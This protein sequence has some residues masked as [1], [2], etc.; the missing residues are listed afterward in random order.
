MAR[1]TKPKSVRIEFAAQRSIK[2][3]DLKLDPENI[4]LAHLSITSQSEIQSH[5][6]N[7]FKLKRLYDDIKNRGL[8]EPLILYPNN[9]IVAEGNCRLS[10]LLK[11]LEQ[12]TDDEI[13]KIKAISCKRISPNTSERDIDAYLA[14]IHVGQKIEWPE[15]NQAKLMHRL[16]HDRGLSLEEISRIVRKTRNLIHFKINAYEETLKY[17]NQLGEKWYDKFVYVW[18][19]VKHKNL[20]DF[21]SSASNTRRFMSWIKDGKF[22]TS[23]DIRY[24]D[25]ILSDKK[26]F[27]LFERYDFETAFNA[28]VDIDPTLKNSAYKKAVDIT[29]ILVKFPRSEV[30]NMCEDKN[31]LRILTNLKN[32]LDE[33]LKEV[34]EVKDY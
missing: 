6:W 11:I 30:K 28:L 32:T 8:Q 31:K 17:S 18:E 24:F 14:E 2:V 5:L 21:R 25:K 27:K 3:G 19:F 16:Y 15:F 7:T 9:N 22:K 12:G 13:N 33:L 4:R 29:K 1:P 26:I 23:K 20:D 10:C 34:K